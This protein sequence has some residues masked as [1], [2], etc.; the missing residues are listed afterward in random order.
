MRITAS[1]EQALKR[2]VEKSKAE[3]KWIDNTVTAAAPTWAGLNTTATTIAQGLGANSRIGDAVRLKSID[4]SWQIVNNGATT[5]MTRVLL[6]VDY[7]SSLGTVSDVLEN[8]GTALSPISP[9]KVSAIPIMKVLYDEVIC[10]DAVQ[11]GQQVARLH[12]KLNLLQTY[13]LSTS[14]PVENVIRLIVL[15]D[16]LGTPPNVD[17]YMRQWYTDE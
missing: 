5:T 7:N 6:Y 16:V 9:I 10:T 14:T 3:L 1:E 15:S 13:K 8:I 11:R 17:I 2:L 12:R 4:V